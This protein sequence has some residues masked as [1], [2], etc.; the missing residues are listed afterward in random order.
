[1]IDRIPEIDRLTML[2]ARLRVQR[3][4]ARLDHAKSEAE[5]SNL[6]QK[7]FDAEVRLRLGLTSAD[8][9]CWETGEITRRGTETTSPAAEEKWEE[10]LNGVGSEEGPEAEAAA[11]GSY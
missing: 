2:N 11:D 1:M 7:L 8:G 6:L 4:I 3:D 5:K 10:E 9:V